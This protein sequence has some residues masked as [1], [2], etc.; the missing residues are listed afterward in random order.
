MVD[1]N[2]NNNIN[3]N[4]KAPKLWGWPTYV[5]IA[6]A[7]IILIFA[8]RF[9]DLKEIWRQIAACD[10]RFVLLG[11][12]AHYATYIVRGMRWRRCLIHLPVKAGSG[13]F[14]LLV[15]FYNF[16]DNLV[17]AKLGDVY[18][19]HL[20]RI[21]FRIRRSAA[22]GSIV[23]LRMID[24]WIVLLLAA[25]ASWMLFADRLP[26]AVFWSLIGGAIIA[27]GATSI[28]LV[29]FLFKKKLPGWIPQKIQQMIQAFHTGM[30]PRAKELFPIAILTITI[31]VLETV[32]IFC[33][34]LAFDLHIGSAEAIFLT[35]I[36]LLASAFPF[37]PSGAGIVEI[38][39]F[40]CLRVVGVTAPI[41][42]S[43][44]VINRFIDYWLHI[45]LGV[46]TWAIRRI[47]GLRT[48]RDV[49]LKKYR[50][51]DSAE[52]PVGR[53]ILNGN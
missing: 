27:A 19:S 13:K 20:A 10:K 6:I 44:T 45:A 7:I 12:L 52:I 53:E 42:G 28:M 35:M 31:W 17:P 24:A 22:L 49:P 50:A 3:N 40:S 14:G 33:L 1:Q 16:V 8:A 25:L 37:T 39:L 30:W 46:L 43:L 41:A 18:A 21:N 23:F 26:G 32:W 4:H 15:F 38:T 36:P 47:I 11:A 48:W 5:S 9:V 29:F 51:N 2:D 34:T